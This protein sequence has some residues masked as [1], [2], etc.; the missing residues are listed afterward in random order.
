MQALPVPERI[1]PWRLATESGRLEGQLALAALSRLA[2]LNR[3]TGEVM[4]ALVGGVDEHGVSFLE[5]SLSTEIELDCQRC[6]GPLRI[7]L[8]VNV[9]LGIIRSETEAER[10]PERYEP[11]LVA[12][13]EVTVADLVEDELLLALPPI[14]RHAALR[15]CEANGYGVSDE[16][17]PGTPLRQPFAVLASLLPDLKRST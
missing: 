14:P 3:A 8:T 2:T 6:L 10:L 11:L 7:P 1:N 9:A 17:T 16:L 12:G 13:T 5:G 15:E 4:V